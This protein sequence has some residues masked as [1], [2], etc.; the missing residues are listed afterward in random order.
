[1]YLCVSVSPP[2]HFCGE[3]R[4]TQRVV[5]HHHLLSPRPVPGSGVWGPPGPGPTREVLAAP[6]AQ[7]SHVGAS[8][9]RSSSREDSRAS[10]GERLSWPAG[11]PGGLQGGGPALPPSPFTSILWPSP[12]PRACFGGRVLPTE[13]GVRP[14]DEGQ[15]F[16][17]NASSRK[18]PPTSP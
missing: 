16:H 5:S 18:E 13:P 4:G 15:G 10:R 12:Q 8:G 1:M 11:A 14:Q 9:Q 17:G 6:Y 2:D 7:G 3:S